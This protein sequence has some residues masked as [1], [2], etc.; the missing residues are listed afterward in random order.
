MEETLMHYLSADS[1]IERI[2]AL[3]AIACK[4]DE[5]RPRVERLV[6]EITRAV[7]EYVTAEAGTA[8]SQVGGGSLPTAGLRT[9]VIKL[10]S[11]KYSPDEIN[12]RLRKCEIPIIAR[13]ADNRV[14]LDLRT[15]QPSEDEILARQIV[16][17]LAGGGWPVERS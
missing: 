8:E 1:L 3:A 12:A 14:I 7:G 4:V 9:A 2:P 13:I 15:V 11:E 5:L 17:A 10:S 6:A 16:T